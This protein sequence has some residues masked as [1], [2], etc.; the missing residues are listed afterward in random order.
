MPEVSLSQIKQNTIPPHLSV[1][2]KNDSTLLIVNS[3]DDDQIIQAQWTF[4]LS[5]DTLLDQTNI[6]KLEAWYANGQLKRTATFKNSKYQGDHKIFWKN[7]Q[8]KRLDRY[9]NGQQ[10]EGKTW[11]ESG[12]ETTYCEYESMPLF[13]GGETGLIKFIARNVRY[14]KKAVKQNI[15]GKVFV[16]FV[17]LKT[18]YVDSVKVVQTIHPL[19]D[20]EALRVVKKLPQWKPGFMDGKNVSV[21]YTVPINFQLN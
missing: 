10:I 2:F 12:K 7:G 15:E 9:E 18:G 5:I 21:R 4:D 19:L 11:D 13:R 17:I 8:L 16:E 1:D 20:Q 3:Y 14:P 6:T